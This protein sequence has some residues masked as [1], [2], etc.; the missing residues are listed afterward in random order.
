MQLTLCASWHHVGMEEESINRSLKNLG[1]D[2]VDLVSITRVSTL[3][4][5]DR[6]VV[7]HALAPRHGLRRP[8]SWFLV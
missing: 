3:T 7:A 4:S 1:L 5:A 8:V 2:Y 6:L